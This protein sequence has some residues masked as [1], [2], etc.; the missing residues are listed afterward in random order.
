[1]VYCLTEAVTWREVWLMGGSNVHLISKTHT[2]DF[3][4]APVL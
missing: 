1:M 3:G 4:F 2:G